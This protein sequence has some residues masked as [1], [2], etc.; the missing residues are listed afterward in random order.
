ME[1][2]FYNK[3]INNI[4]KKYKINDK[5]LYKHHP[6][7]SYQNWNKKKSELQCSMLELDI[8]IQVKYFFVVIEFKQYIL[9][10]PHL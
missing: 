5:I 3:L 1:I 2:K 8:H 7:I 9:V 6:R 10:T 4:T